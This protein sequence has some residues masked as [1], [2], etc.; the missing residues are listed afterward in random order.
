MSEDLIAEKAEEFERAW[1]RVEQLTEDAINGAC[2]VD[3]ACAAIAEAGRLEVELRC[4][5]VRYAVLGTQ[6]IL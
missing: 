5:Q 2:S 6:S 4:A 3:E 1:A